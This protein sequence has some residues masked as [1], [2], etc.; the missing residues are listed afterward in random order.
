MNNNTSMNN[1]SNR[2]QDTSNRKHKEFVLRFESPLYV[3]AFT[4][5]KDFIIL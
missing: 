1:E 2:E 3:P 4:A 5:I